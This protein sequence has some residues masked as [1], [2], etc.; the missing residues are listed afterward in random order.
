ME[1]LEIKTQKPSLFTKILTEKKIPNVLLHVLFYLVLCFGNW[2]GMRRSILYLLAT[3]NYNQYV[4]AILGNEL[5]AFLTA[6]LIP[7]LV[8]QVAR[9]L[10]HGP[11]RMLGHK[12]VSD[13]EYVLRVFYGVGNLAYGLFTLL[14]L[15]FPTLSVYGETL[16]RFLIIGVFVLLCVLFEA[17]TRMPKRFTP[18]LFYSYCVIYCMLNGVYAIY[19]TI[20]FVVG[21]V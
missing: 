8:Y 7:M 12:S 16:A 15:P 11:F 5:V 1:N 19:T 20:N 17:K 13:M 21:L 18:R 4:N 10:A 2:Y 9:L 14:Y 6:G 3:G